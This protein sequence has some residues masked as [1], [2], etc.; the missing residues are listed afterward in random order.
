DSS[1]H[2]LG[3]IATDDGVPVTGK[4]SGGQDWLRVSYKGQTGFASE[5]TL[6]SVDQDEFDAWN[7]AKTNPTYDKVWNFLERYHIGYFKDKGLAL[8]ES[9]PRTAAPST[10]AS[11]APKPG[12]VE[13]SPQL[14][15]GM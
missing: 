6:T 2:L 9:L 5:D 10:P 13:L 15:S 4:V 1:S 7:A 3:R 11:L 12:T 8:L 14:C